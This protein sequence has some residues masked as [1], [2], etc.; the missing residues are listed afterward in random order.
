MKTEMT[1]MEREGNGNGK[2]EEEKN[3]GKNM[4]RVKTKRMNRMVQIGR[5]GK[6]KMGK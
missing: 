4:E 3:I 5:M 2:E 1:D 6:R